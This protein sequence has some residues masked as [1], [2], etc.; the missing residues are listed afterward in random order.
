MKETSG[1]MF[2]RRKLSDKAAQVML[3]ALSG[4]S[5]DNVDAH[6]RS[7]LYKLAYMLEQNG[8]AASADTVT[9]IADKT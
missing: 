6:V 9:K 4:A 2:E 8:R 5:P 3:D 1:V 7:M